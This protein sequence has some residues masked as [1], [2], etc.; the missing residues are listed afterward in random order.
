[1]DEAEEQDLLRKIAQHIEEVVLGVTAENAACSA[2]GGH[3]Q[4]HA[5]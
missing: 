4:K 2:A 3:H 1:M 5:V